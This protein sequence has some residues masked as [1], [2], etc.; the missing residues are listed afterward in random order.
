MINNDQN[1]NQL[2]AAFAATFTDLKNTISGFDG[3]TF[4]H[5]PLPGSWTAGQV[6]EH[7]I[8]S[9]SGLPDRN[10]QVANRPANEW[11]QAIKDMFLDFTI[12]FEADPRIQPTKSSHS[13]SEVLAALQET[14]EKLQEITLTA[15]LEMLCLDLKL[16]VFGYLTRYEWL[17]LILY[18]TQRHTHQIRNIYRA[19][20]EES[21][22]S[23][24]S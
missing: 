10:T 1:R 5:T 11:V 8:K 14:E 6:A 7:L 18:H 15:D 23:K 2:V 13:K 19:L 17:H 22:V 21:R 20:N 4:N 3:D 16:P 24:E 9:A 12:K